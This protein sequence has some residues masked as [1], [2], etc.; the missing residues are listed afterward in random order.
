MVTT[1]QRDFPHI[2]SQVDNKELKHVEKLKIF[3]VNID[4]KITILACSMG[5]IY[6]AKEILPQF[7]LQHLHN[8]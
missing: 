6:R 3:S 4:H 1:D 8:G 7:G 5:I 2:S